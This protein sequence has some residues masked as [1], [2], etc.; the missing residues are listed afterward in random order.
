MEGKVRSTEFW[1]DIPTAIRSRCAHCIVV[2]DGRA[3]AS[4]RSASKLVW[5]IWA[6]VHRSGISETARVSRS[7]ASW[8]RSVGTAM[9]IRAKPAPSRPNQWPGL[10]AR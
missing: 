5:E 7:I 10:N 1:N 9:V 2:F 6:R 4:V 8:M 3:D